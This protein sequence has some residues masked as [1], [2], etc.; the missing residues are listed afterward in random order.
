MVTHTNINLHR[1]TV[2][3]KWESS[4]SDTEPL[5]FSFLSWNLENKKI[6]NDVFKIKCGKR[7]QNQI[8]LTNDSSRLKKKKKSFIAFIWLSRVTFERL[9]NNWD[10]DKCAEKPSVLGVDTD[11]TSYSLC[12]SYPHDSAAQSGCLLP[13]ILLY[14]T[15]GHEWWKLTDMG[16]AKGFCNFEL[17]FIVV[18]CVFFVCF[19][20]F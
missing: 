9:K 19:V 15:S 18:F 2:A 5:Y 13:Q 17:F 6:W 16:F 3:K 8:S 12:K 1:I 20:L 11:G 10:F 4:L 14:H 7:T